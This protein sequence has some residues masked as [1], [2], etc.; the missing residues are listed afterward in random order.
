MRSR[1][2]KVAAVP[3]EPGEHAADG[4]NAVGAQLRRR[5]AERSSTGRILRDAVTP[6]LGS[7]FPSLRKIKVGTCRVGPV[8]PRPVG[9]GRDPR[10]AAAGSAPGARRSRARP[11]RSLVP[12][13]PRS[14]EAFAR[15]DPTRARRGDRR[16]TDRALGAHTTRADGED[17]HR[18]QGRDSR[19]VD[20]GL[21]RQRPMDTVVGNIPSISSGQP[22][23]RAGRSRPRPSATSASSSTPMKRG[24]CSRSAS[25]DALRGI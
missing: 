14:R 7:S 6:V 22:T 13:T 25:S 21:P 19:P 17:V 18:D 2:G 16:R 9:C 4:A 11:G 8:R 3:V 20:F 23:G 15:H 1:Q 24:A 12:V 10:T 5:R